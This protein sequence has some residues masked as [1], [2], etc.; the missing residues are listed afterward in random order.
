MAKNI[1]QDIK[2]L[3]SNGRRR[4][5]VTEAPQEISPLPRKKVEQYINVDEPTQNVS[6]SRP[7]Y[8]DPEMSD[9][10]NPPRRSRGRIWTIVILVL[11]GMFVALSYAFEEATV[12]VT[13]K[14]ETV[15]LDNNFTA[16]KDA[17]DGEL[18]FEV[19]AISGEE[20]KTFTGTEKRDAN[21]KAT[22][23]VVIYNEYSTTAQNLLIETRL[24]TKDGKIYK[25]DKAVK[26]PGYTK[27]GTDIVPGSIEVG[28]HADVSGEDYNIPPSDF[29]LIGLKG[30]PKYTKIYARSST[31]I[32]GGAKG[33]RYILSNDEKDKS[34]EE[35]ISVLKDK[36]LKQAE[37]QIP[38]G[39][40]YYDGGVFFDIDDSNM[41][42]ESTSST[43]TGTAKGKLSM[44]LFD[45]TKL[46]EAIAKA[47]I[48]QYD[49]TPVTIPELHDLKF[50]SKTAQDVDITT[51]TSVPF[52]LSGDTHIISVIDSEKLASELAGKN[53]NTD[54]Q[55]VFASWSGIDSAEIS[56]RPLWKRTLPENP[57]DIKIKVDESL[58][59]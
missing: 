24:E 39:F 1:L 35:L 22:G 43:I 59:Q 6:V 52:K 45:Q 17:P 23:K 54:A 12:A 15:T 28:V 4:P 20:S 49:G 29:T 26:V 11:L 27:K 25:T 30:S 14:V 19:V 21:D 16:K 40:V 9:T 47:A 8:K 5:V 36:L 7:V 46:T 56:M 51:A 41:S 31:A 18:P 53:K 37:S 42:F 58:S 34:T 2:P 55:T 57:T 48:S 13:P 33:E 3:T 10:V 38:D 50:E 44:L 32:S